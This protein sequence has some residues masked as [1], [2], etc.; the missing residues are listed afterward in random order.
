MATSCPESKWKARITP[1]ICG[2]SSTPCTARKVPTAGMR[3]IQS[4][5]L[6]SVTATVATGGGALLMKPLII[7]GL[8]T[9]WK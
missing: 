4:S 5:F 1:P 9:N 3:S 7:S 2:A 8:K 6:A